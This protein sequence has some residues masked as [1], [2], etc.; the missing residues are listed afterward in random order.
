MILSILVGWKRG[1]SGSWICVA[2][3]ETR[4]KDSI[5]AK[6]HEKSEA[7]LRAVRHAQA[8]KL[9]IPNAGLPQAPDKTSSGLPHGTLDFPLHD[10]LVESP[11]DYH[12]THNDL[13][14][15]VTPNTINSQ[16][17][18]SLSLFESIFN[19]L[20]DQALSDDEDV[21]RSDPEE[22]ELL[23]IEGRMMPHRKVLYFLLSDLFFTNFQCCHQ[24]LSNLIKNFDSQSPCLTISGTHGQIN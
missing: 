6:R 2:C 24:K 23:D 5:T 17:G 3:A 11:P 22:I 4:L 9:S 18:G 8:P 7:H 12:H 1:P 13:E 16:D 15:P 14:V 10:L 19:F 20:D 21:E